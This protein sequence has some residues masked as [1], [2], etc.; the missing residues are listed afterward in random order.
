VI[1][2][3]EYTKTLASL[4]VIGCAV[5]NRDTFYFLAR[6]DY[7]ATH[8][9]REAPDELDLEKRVISFFRDEVQSQRWGHTSLRD[10]DLLSC[11]MSVDPK[12]QLVAVS[13][14]GHVFAIG[15]GE[16]GLEDMVSTRGAVTRVRL[17]GT[18]AYLCGT[19]RIV[20]RRDAKNSW[21]AHSNSISLTKSD[22]HQ[23]FRDISGFSESDVYAV[24]GAGDIWNYDGKRWK[25]CTFPSNQ[26]LFT[27]CCA[28]DGKVYVSGLLGTTFVGKDDTWKLI[29]ESNMTIPFKDMVW[30]ED[31]VWCTSDYGLWWIKDGKLT[32]ATVPSDVKLCSGYLSARDGVLLV[33]GFGGA[34]FLEKGKWQLIFHHS[35]FKA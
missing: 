4:N 3:G 20:C 34:A 6:E 15:S 22:R 2:Q 8:P 16:G 10:F 19:P 21:H 26:L 33:A 17:I 18:H 9:G 14:G 30:Y 29:Y 35:A 1:S 11:G 31:R 32:E 25:K 24:G 7:T 27:V 23:G 13:L 12:Q 28:G 5:R